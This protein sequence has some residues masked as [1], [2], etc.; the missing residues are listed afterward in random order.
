M[1]L[2]LS[3]QRVRMLLCLGGQR[4]SAAI[5]FDSQNARREPAGHRR[6]T[7]VSVNGSIS[8]SVGDTKSRRLF[9]KPLQVRDLRLRHRLE[10][11]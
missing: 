10:V 7:N 2:G 11:S 8:A 6:R 5:Y 9:A 1:L 3:G 4:L